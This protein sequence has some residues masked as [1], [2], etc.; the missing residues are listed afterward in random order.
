M[1]EKQYD[2]FTE[3]I[4]FGGLR[5][6]NEIRVLLCYLLKNIDCEVSKSGLNE[7]L[8]TTE[9][10]NFFESNSSLA[11]LAED[12]LVHRTVRDGEEFY[13][14]TEEGKDFA[15]KLDT[16]LPLHVREAVVKAAIGIV[17]REKMR[18]VVD[19]RTEKLEKGCNVI[20]TIRDGGDIMMQTVLYA[21]DTM[22]AEAVGES[23]MKCPEKLYGGIIDLL[24][25][26]E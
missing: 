23:F 26:G 6:K 9:L 20:M 16:A 11:A 13:S 3:G 7:I 18:G 22:Q 8:Q 1:A 12:G 25:S 14:L 2:A 10:V 21:A 17:A 15:D 4:I 19:V 5:T 24:T